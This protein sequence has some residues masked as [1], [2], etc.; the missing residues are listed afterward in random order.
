MIVAFD[1]D[2][3]LFDT[4]AYH[5]AVSENGLQH[6]AVTPELFTKLNP[7]PFLF[8]DV[9]VFLKTQSRDT[10]Y[11]VSAIS[12]ELGPHAGEYQREKIRATGMFEQVRD[13]IL[14]I[15]TKAP[16]LLELVKNHPNETIWF[17]DD[18]E[19]NLIDARACS[20]WVR[21]LRIARNGLT[22]GV[23]LDVPTMYQLSDLAHY[24]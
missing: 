19:E 16:A 14:V 13:V 17:V 23:D 15:G 6:L 3:T 8:S 7:A 9:H 24:G 10:V 11:I 22:P 18:K 4:D 2:R 20:P 1:F 5:R 21:P 12:P